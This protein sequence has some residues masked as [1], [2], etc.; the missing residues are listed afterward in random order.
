[1]TFISIFVAT[2]NPDRI[3]KLIENLEQTADDWT[4]FE[5]LIKLD[6]GD[7]V[8][9]AALDALKTKSR[10]N[11]RY[12]FGPKLD[13]Y[14]SLQVGYNALRTLM[15]PDSYFC[16]LFNDEIRILTQGWDTKLKK[17]IKLYDD[18]VFRLKTSALKMHSHYDMSECLPCP[19]NY[20]VTTRKWLELTEGWG[21]FWGDRKSVV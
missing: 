7:T 20:A 2:I 14:Y 4:N 3:S 6:D 1:M 16:W 5:V 10:V 12:M 8:T 9:G 19:D 11:F 17:Y 13:G 15:S 21:D 18:D